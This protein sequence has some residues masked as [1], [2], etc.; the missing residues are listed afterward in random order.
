MDSNK[1]VNYIANRTKLGIDLSNLQKRDRTIPLIKSIL[2]K[3]NSNIQA[4]TRRKQHRTW[5]WNYFWYCK[6]SILI[7]FAIKSDNFWYVGATIYGFCFFLTFLLLHST[8]E[9]SMLRQN[10]LEILDHISIY[11]L[12]AGTYSVLLNV[13]A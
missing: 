2:C 12:I 13:Y 1:M 5:F 8:T 7:A 3:L 4:R 11:F 9:S 10:A 6:Y